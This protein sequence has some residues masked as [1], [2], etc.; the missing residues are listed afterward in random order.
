MVLAEADPLEAGWDV[1]EMTAPDVAVEDVTVEVVAVEDVTVVDVALL[2]AVVLVL[3][4]V[5]PCFT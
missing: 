2:V 1:E 4:E 5:E 3:E